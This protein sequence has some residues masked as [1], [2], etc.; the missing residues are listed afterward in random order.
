MQAYLF[1]N[2]LKRMVY[3]VLYMSTGYLAQLVGMHGM[4]LQPSEEVALTIWG[5]AMVGFIKCVAKIK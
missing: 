1:F 4:Q 2:V 5:K 3:I